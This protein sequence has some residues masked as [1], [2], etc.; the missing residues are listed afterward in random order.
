MTNVTGSVLVS[1]T[2][3]AASDA[4]DV[5]VALRRVLGEVDA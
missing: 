4:V 3:S 1:G 2:T 5:L